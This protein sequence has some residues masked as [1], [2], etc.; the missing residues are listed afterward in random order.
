LGLEA[1]EGDFFLAIAIAQIVTNIIAVDI[2]TSIVLLN[3]GT[4]GLGATVL[5]E[6][7]VEESEN[8]DSPVE[9]APIIAPIPEA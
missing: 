4:V 1:S 3:S 7:G 9:D 2:V 5:V 8:T 6:V